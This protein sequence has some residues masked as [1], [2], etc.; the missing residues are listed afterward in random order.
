ML[1]NESRPQPRLDRNRGNGFTV[2]VGRVRPAGHVTENA[3]DV[4][5]AFKFTLL[6]HNT[7]LGAAGS[8]IMNAELAVAK[9]YIKK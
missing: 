8:A 6:S 5:D 9:G 3:D 7:I 1:S 4:Y 2:T